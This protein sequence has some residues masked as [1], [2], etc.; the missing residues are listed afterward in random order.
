[1]PLCGCYIISEILDKDSV[2]NDPHVIRA[3]NVAAKVMQQVSK[4]AERRASMPANFGKPWTDEENTELL[5]VFD[6]KM[7][8]K[9]I[10]AKHGRAHT[11][12]AARLVKL[13]RLENRA[14]AW[15]L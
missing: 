9:E 15:N 6:A 2:F 5:T 8:L 12:I 13:D 3:L 4:N 1:M 14:E 7:P 10:A 11:A